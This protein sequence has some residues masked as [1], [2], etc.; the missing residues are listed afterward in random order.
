MIIGYAKSNAFP[1][2]KSCW[3]NIKRNILKVIFLRKSEPFVNKHKVAVET[4]QN[5]GHNYSQN[6]RFFKLQN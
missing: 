3:Q 6:Y 1:R 4:W 2:K 5:M